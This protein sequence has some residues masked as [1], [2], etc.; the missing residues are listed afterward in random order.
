M[1]TI[2]LMSCHGRKFIA[3]IRGV[4]CEGIITIQDGTIYLCQNKANGSNCNEKHGY[5]YSW[6]IGRGTADNLLTNGVTDL[7]VTSTS[8]MIHDW[9]CWNEGNVLLAPSNNK[10]TIIFRHNEVFVLKDESNVGQIPFTGEEL[11]EKGYKLLIPEEK[12]KTPSSETVSVKD[13]TE[14][15]RKPRSPKL[16][17]CH[18]RKFTAIIEG[19][20]VE[21]KISIYAGHVYLCQNKYA[22]SSLS[23]AHRLGY[24]YAS[25]I[26]KYYSDLHTYGVKDFTLLPEEESSSSITVGPKK[27]KSTT[28]APKKTKDNLLD[29]DGRKFVADIDVYTGVKGKIR[30]EGK[31][32]YL[33]QNEA[34]GFDCENK[35]GY[36]YSWFVDNGSK[37]ALAKECVKNFRLITER[38]KKSTP[39]IETVE[40][41]TPERTNL[42]DC[43]GKRFSATILGTEVEGRIQVE[44]GYVFLCQNSRNGASCTDKLGY[45]YSWVVGNGSTCLNPDYKFNFKLLDEEEEVKDN[46]SAPSPLSLVPTVDTIMEF[47]GA[48]FICDIGATRNVKGKVHIYDGRVFLCQNKRDGSQGDKKL[49]Y[50]YSWFVTYTNTVDFTRESVSNFRITALASIPAPEKK[51]P[52][53]NLLD[54]HGK[55]FTAKIQRVEV[56]GRIAVESDRVYLCQDEKD[57]TR[58]GD[59]LGYDYSWTVGDG[60][61]YSL[62]A[63]SVTDFMIVESQTNDEK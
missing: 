62:E 42:L 31:R 18:G 52:P 9:R 63:N 12:L 49:G 59:T 39:K 48:S 45:K 22:N 51:A 14:K 43:K 3:K 11:V 53:I 16:T 15:K 41:K 1:K 6:L 55:R 21:G 28:A 60:S 44:E 23:A 10:F 58:C 24:K 29:C 13:N 8:E 30:V 32:V 36:R 56:E 27:T 4:Q 61:K 40:T 20:K 7:V 46:T 57:G 33:C 50:K 35:L 19:K 37:S 25:M 34:D 26:G 17:K 38:K 5:L 2:D 47:E 54:S